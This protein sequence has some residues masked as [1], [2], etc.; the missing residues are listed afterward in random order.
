MAWIM[1]MAENM[2]PTA[3]EALVPIWLTKKVSAIL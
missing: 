2:T 1:A 3:P